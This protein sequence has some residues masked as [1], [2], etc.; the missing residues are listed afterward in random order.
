MSDSTWACV[1]PNHSVAPSSRGISVPIFIAM[2]FYLSVW[3]RGVYVCHAPAKQLAVERLLAGLP[4]SLAE[5]AGLQRVN[6]AQRFFRR[7]ADV[8]IVHDLVTKHAFGIDH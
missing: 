3:E 5:S 8:Q 6:H 2:F 1:P 7:A 4:F